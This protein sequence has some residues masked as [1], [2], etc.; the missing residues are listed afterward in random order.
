MHNKIK[1]KLVSSQDKSSLISLQSGIIKPQQLETVRRI[2]NKILEKTGKIKFSIKPTL[3]LT[4]KS[5]GVPLGC[6]K[7][8]YFA[9]YATIATGQEI[10]SV[11]HKDK[12]LVK[13]ALMKVQIKLPVS[14]KICQ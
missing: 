2:I 10:I 12:K 6:G 7:G 3:T 13:L 11:I 14:T 1:S 5:L 4:K 9:T 8:K